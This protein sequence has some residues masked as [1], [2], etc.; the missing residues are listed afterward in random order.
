MTEAE[1]RRLVAE[2]SGGLCEMVVPHQCS[3]RARSLH[4]R[5]KASQGGAWAPANIL[6]ACGSGTTG[7]HGWVEAHPH[8]ANANGWWLFT[9]EL[10]ELTPAYLSWRG[11]R[12]WYQL[13][14]DGSLTW[15]PRR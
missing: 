12:D 8:D 6:A 2:R 11:V 7:C 14:D 9:G 5:R 13:G 1:C 4:H 3:G 10:P 15:R